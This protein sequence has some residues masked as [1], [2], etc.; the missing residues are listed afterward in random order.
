MDTYNFWLERLS[1]I[2]K[3]KGQRNVLFLAADRIG[4]EFSY[5]DKKNI[6]FLGS[7]C[8]ISINPHQLIDRLDKKSEKVL[9][10]SYKFK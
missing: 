6:D 9:K 8:A 5:Y 7:S 10:I 2:L 1:P 3:P 4:Q